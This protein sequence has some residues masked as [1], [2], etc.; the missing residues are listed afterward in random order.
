MADLDV[1]EEKDEY[2][3]DV[4]KITKEGFY[5]SNS[6]VDSATLQKIKK[7]IFPARKLANSQSNNGLQS[8]HY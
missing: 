3:E 7:Q 8:S 5:K 4:D 6:T 1:L 2:E